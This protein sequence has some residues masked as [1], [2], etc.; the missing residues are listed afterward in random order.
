MTPN[1]AFKIFFMLGLI[2][3]CFLMPAAGVLNAAAQ[4]GGS[5]KIRAD[6]DLV[7]VEVTVLDSKGKPVPN[8][9]KEDFQLYEDLKK[10]EILSFDEVNESSGISS[11]GVVPLNEENLPRGKTV[12]IIFDNNSI[13]RGFFK[14]SRESAD[15]FVREHMK[16]HDLFAVASYSSTM[17]FL[18]NLTSDRELVLAAI[19]Q[20]ANN[21]REL[22]NLRNAYLEELF[23]SL[24][25]INY[26]IAPL[27]GQKS[28][29]LYGKTD[30]HSDNTVSFDTTD[31]SYF[32]MNKFRDATE[33]ARRSNV[34]YYTIDPSSRAP[35]PTDQDQQEID[36]LKGIVGQQQMDAKTRIPVGKS[37]RPSFS[38]GRISGGFSIYDQNN[39]DGEL[40]KLNQ[41]ISNY[42]ILGFQSNNPKRDGA[43]RNL[44][45]RTK[46]KGVTLRQYRY[47]YWDQR[48]IDTLASSRYEKRLLTA[49]ASPTATAAQLPIVFRTAY[50]YDPPRLTRVLVEARISTEKM[51]FKKKGDERSADINIMGVAYAEDGSVAARFSRTIAI[52]LETDKE[53][54][55]RKRG[56]A[57][58]NYFRLRPGKYRLKLAASD[59][60]NNLGAVEQSLEIPALPEKG[61]AG[62]SIVL[63]E[64]TS[65]LPELI[66]NIRI[67]L[68]DENN[69]LVFSGMQIEPRAENKLPVNS[70]ILVLFRLYNLSGPSDRWDLIAK[71]KLL[72]E[73][74]GAIDLASISLKSIISPVAGG[75]GVVVLKLPSQG[76]APGKYKL[77][78]EVADAASAETASIET[79]LEFVK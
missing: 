21:M 73:K 22:A 79:D 67:Q 5:F 49:L 61:L 66:Q 18:Q 8:L 63:A 53:T 33:S 4:S 71:P 10:Q 78:I 19:A 36:K 26:S 37:L 3:L 45:V 47:G 60:S 64:Q 11:L 15:R 48:P 40:D 6:V 29:L 59:E 56:F 70:E 16:P 2:N 75:Q 55:F 65:P 38:L 24:A 39:I 32:I 17:D 13:E 23:R 76:V 1:Q 74:G 62:S 44:A 41:Q 25:K 69:P 57:Y 12:L 20:S 43:Y 77:N 34:V 9:K 51:A 50:F 30:Y 35:E 42:Y 46:L 7:P 27:K 68:L 72:N 58:R 52:N 54:E 28:V 14:K 31:T